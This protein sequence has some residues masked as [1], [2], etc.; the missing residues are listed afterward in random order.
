MSTERRLIVNADDFGVTAGVSRGIL[1][2][3]RHG[4]VRSTTAMVN[5]PGEA[6]LD[7]E[8]GS[9]AALGIGLHLN[10]T[11]GRPVAPADREAM[12]R[13]A[14]A[15]GR[16]L[17]VGDEQ[18]PPDVDAFE[19]WWS[20]QLE[21]LS[22]DAQVR[23]YMHAVLDAR[24][25]P[26]YLRPAMPLQRLV[27]R[28]LLPPRL[29]ELFGFAWSERDERR[30]QRFRRWAPRLYWSVPRALRQWPAAYY[31]GRLRQGV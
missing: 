23:D 26:W 21:R 15:F 14:W 25:A 19:R 20:T 8:A 22:V 31:L 18:W 17:Q 3:V 2:A 27:T 28:G 13:E 4:V 30:W 11:W 1:D 7:A 5:L 12:Y 16:T 29:R 24:H 10:L 9:L 6:A